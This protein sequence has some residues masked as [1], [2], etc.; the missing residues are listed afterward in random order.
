VDPTN[1]ISSVRTN[2]AIGLISAAI[3]AFQLALMQIL[4]Y[5]QWYHFAYMIISIAL[6]GFGAAGTFLT[7]FRKT[8]LQNY[9]RTFPLLLIITAILIPVVILVA[10]AKPVRFDSLLIF[11]DSSHAGRLIATCF[12]FFL[13]FFTGALAIGLSFLKFAG[14]IGKIYFSNLMG[15]GMGGAVAVLL[16]QFILPEQLPLYIALIALAGGFVSFPRHAGK[17]LLITTLVSI[18]VLPVLFFH[19]PHLKPSEYKDISKTLLL[20]KATIEFEKS[21]PHGLVQVVSSPVLR[22]APGVS[23]SYGAPYPIRKAVFNN[24]NWVGYQVPASGRQKTS[25]LD[26]T[27]QSLPYHIGKMDKV[28]VLDA[29][30]GENISLAL[31]HNVPVIVANEA[32]AEIFKLLQNSFAGCDEVKLHQT[33]ARTLLATGASGYDLIELPVIG[34]F[35]GNSGLNAVETRYELSI[36]ALQEMWDK[37]SANGMISLGCWMDYPV[38][39]AYRLLSTIELLLERKNIRHGNEHIMAVRSWSAVTFL[40]KKSE[41]SRNQVIQAQQFCDQLMFDPLIL[42]GMKEINHGKYN[43]LQDTSFFS[44]TERLLSSGRNAFIKEYA[45]RVQ[46]TTDNRPFFFQHIRWSGIRQAIASFN[47]GNAPFPELGYL[48][49]LLT[50]IQLIII[51]AIFIM[52]PMAFTSWKSQHK[53]RVFMYFSGIGLAYMFIEIVFIQQFTFYFGQATYATAA[54]ISILLI[55]SGLGSYYSAKLQNTAKMLLRIP[56]L[57]A[58]LLL[59]YTLLL[60]PVLSLTIGVSLPVKILI[61]MVLLG[62]PGFLLG[63]PFPVG[64]KHLTKGKQED[65]PWAWAFNG[66]FSV[67]STALATIVSVEAGYIWLLLIAAFTYVLAGVANLGIKPPVHQ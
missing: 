4:S 1:E 13:P 40:V 19:T 17:S 63:L 45:F 31:S 41:F 55:A 11:H 43:L 12:I 65:I 29:G 56:L 5:V 64:I 8:L 46:P 28:L 53:I 3:I 67:I 61:S 15:S 66:Y 36:E 44:N 60:S 54:T 50:F 26:Y 16:L 24:G 18:I 42:P 14:Q 33:M 35:F 51:A 57:I 37:L 20:P 10:N 39:N 34:S 6:L 27:P 21:S 9:Y 23:L 38:R 7:F 2:I 48:L 25:M 58:A 30:T 62:V 32:N 59:L 22:F 52:L 47:E 49:V